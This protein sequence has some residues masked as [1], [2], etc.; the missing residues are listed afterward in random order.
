MLQLCYLLSQGAVLH[1][2]D[3]GHGIV[4]TDISWFLSL[5]NK[6]LSHLEKNTA[7]GVDPN[8]AKGCHF[9]ARSTLEAHLA[10]MTWTSQEK[11]MVSWQNLYFSV[12][13]TFCFQSSRFLPLLSCF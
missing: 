13:L 4:V 11:N 1:I 7:A 6:I 8:L 2:P 3:E 12:I 9:T 5:M 10:T